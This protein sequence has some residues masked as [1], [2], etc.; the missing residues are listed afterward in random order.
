MQWAFEVCGEILRYPRCGQWYQPMKVQRCHFSDTHLYTVLHSDTEWESVPMKVQPC[1]SDDT[2]LYTVLHSDTQWES[3]P[4][5]VQRCHFS[6]TLLYTVLHSDKST[7]MSP[8]L[9]LNYTTI[10]FT[11]Q[12]NTHYQLYCT[13]KW[14]E[15]DTRFQQYNS[16]HTSK[17]E[18]WWKVKFLC[19]REPLMKL[20]GFQQTSWV[21]AF[22]SVRVTM[23]L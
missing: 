4:M 17:Y 18:Q 6:D 21:F 7:A 15:N 19:A 20:A 10:W 14:S 1:H 9:K 3:V 16:G 8:P 12:K 5:K 11:K 2:H 22:V 23:Y 13:T